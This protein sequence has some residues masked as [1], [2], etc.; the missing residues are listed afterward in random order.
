M[1]TECYNLLIWPRISQFNHPRISVTALKKVD[2]GSTVERSARWSPGPSS[3]VGSSR[4]SPWVSW[5]KDAKRCDQRRW[6]PVAKSWNWKCVM[7]IFELLIDTIEIYRNYWNTIGYMEIPRISNSCAW[8]EWETIFQS[9]LDEPGSRDR[10]SLFKSICCHG[11]AFSSHWKWGMAREL[12][13][14]L[15]SY[16][17]VKLWLVRFRRLKPRM[18]QL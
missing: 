4:R 5:R 7:A 2:D 17:N 1:V 6:A 12:K 18:K 3:W 14:L 16:S 13:S 9:Q 11:R 8:H 15:G 10:G